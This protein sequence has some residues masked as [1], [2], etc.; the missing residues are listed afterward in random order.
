MNFLIF[1]YFFTFSAYFSEIDIFHQSQFLALSNNKNQFSRGQ[2]EGRRG[3]EGGRGKGSEEREGKGGREGGREREREGGRGRNRSPKGNMW[4]A[5]P[6]ALLCLIVNWSEG[7][8]GSAPEGD[9]VL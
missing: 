4:S 7:K 9:E 5:I 1:F 6:V 3:R 2:R 8:Q